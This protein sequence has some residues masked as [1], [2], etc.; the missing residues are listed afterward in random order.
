MH[1]LAIGGRVCI[2][3][4]DA[5]RLGADFPG[6]SGT[7]LRFVLTVDS[8]MIIGWPEGREAEIAVTPLEGSAWKVLNQVGVNIRALSGDRVPV[9]L[10]RDGRELWMSVAADGT[11][12]HGGGRP[13]DAILNADS[14]VESFWGRNGRL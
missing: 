2:S 6:L 10:P 3:L 14:V 1:V 13:L 8:G 7:V 12:S 4:D 5:K 9:C 11:V